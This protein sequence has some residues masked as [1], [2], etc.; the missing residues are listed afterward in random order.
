MIWLGLAM[1]LALGFGVYIGLGAPGT[2]GRTD[3]VVRPGRSRRLEHR[4]IHWIRPRGR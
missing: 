4:H 2:G 3:R 1:V